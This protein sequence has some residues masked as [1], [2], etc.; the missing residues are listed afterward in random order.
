[1]PNRRKS[2][3]PWYSSR[4]IG[5]DSSRAANLAAGGRDR[6]AGAPEALRRGAGARRRVVRRPRR[7]R[8]SGC[9]GRTARA[10]RRPSACS[11]RSRTPTA[12]RRRSAG[13]DVRREPNAVRRTI[14][15]VPQES[16]VDRFGTGRENLALQGRVQGMGGRDLQ[17]ARRRAARARRDR[18]RR[19]PRRP[20][21]SG[22]MQRR[23]DIAIGLVHRPRVL[24]LDEPTTGLDPEARV[25]MW[26]EVGRLAEA[27]VADDPADDPLPRGGRPAGR[28][29]R[30]RLAGQGRRRGHA[31]RAEGERCA[32]TPCRSSSRTGTSTEAQTAARRDGRQS[33]R[34]CS[35]AARSS[36][37]SR[38]AAARCPGSSPRSTPPGS[39]WNASSVSRPSL[40]DVYLS[41]TGRDFN[42]EDRG[43]MKI[44]TD[45][46]FMIVRQMRNLMREPIWIVAD[47]RAADGLAAA[48][49]AALQERHAARRLR[50]D[51]VHHV[52]R[53]G[54]RRHER[55]LRRDVERHVDD[56]R[57]RPQGRRAV[58]RDAGVA[59][60]RS[61]SRRS[62][63]RRSR[64]RSR[65]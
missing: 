33:R 30:D 41:F 35:T 23:L 45:T 47:A 46:W 64:R 12:A 14:G 57:P 26:A 25:A 38:T 58:P 19:R 27:G 18:R 24:F 5:G 51:V 52:P 37:A 17:P 40:D 36:R 63:A 6:R 16:G 54:D 61:C 8:S 65:R 32:A 11:S 7:A 50:H 42:T 29:P 62:C 34:P 49:R 3:L 44:P 53:A 2:C 43:E 22:G 13:H 9:S 20:T 59:A 31:G 1:M 55:V 60:S 10:S 28:P 56:R 15:Y 48:L 4:S 39:R 21:Y